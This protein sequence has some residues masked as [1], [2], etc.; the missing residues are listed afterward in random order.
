[1]PTSVPIAVPTPSWVGDEVGFRGRVTTKFDPMTECPAPTPTTCSHAVEQSTIFGT[2]AH[3]LVACPAGVVNV[4]VEDPW[5]DAIMHACGAETREHNALA[6]SCAD[7]RFRDL[8]LDELNEKFY[9]TAGASLRRANLTQGD[10]GQNLLDFVTGFTTVRLKGFNL[11]NSRA[12]VLSPTVKDKE[13]QTIIY[14]N[15][16]DV[17]CVLGDPSV[18]SSPINHY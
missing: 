17:S 1:M 2:D 3:H 6:N 14:H 4:F 12:E 18:L 8:A 15:S 10:P 16:T 5:T 7:A 13:C 9:L 11:G